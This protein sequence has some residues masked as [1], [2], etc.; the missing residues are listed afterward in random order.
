MFICLR[1][2]YSVTRKCRIAHNTEAFLC[3]HVKSHNKFHYLSILTYRHTLSL[4]SK[5]HSWLNLQ[6]EDLITQFDNVSH[7]ISH[8]DIVSNDFDKAEMHR[9]AADLLESGC[10]CNV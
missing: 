6:V 1:T 7:L 2:E 8:T 5:S 9:H 4:S 10:C 3:L